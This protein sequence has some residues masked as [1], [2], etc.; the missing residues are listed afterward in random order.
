MDF[1]I[2]SLVMLLAVIASSWVARILPSLLPLPLIQIGLG[3]L[4]GLTATYRVTLAPD[5]F[6]LLFL[7]PLLFV[8]AWRSP[9]DALL[10][11]GLPIFQLAVGLVI[12]SVLG[13]GFAIHWTMSFVPLAVAFALAAVL[14]PTDAVAVSA[15][16]ERWAMPPRLLTILKGEALL[17]DASSLVC[18]HLA[19]VAALTGRFSIT[20][21]FTSFFALAIG[22][23]AIGIATT[24]LVAIVKYTIAYRFREDPTNQILIS[25]LMPFIAYLASEE[26]GVS[27]VLAA[28]AAGLTMSYVKSQGRAL[29]LTR[30][31]RRVVWDTVQATL[32]GMIFVL[33][34]EQLP[35]VVEGAAYTAAEAGHPSRWWLLACIVAVGVGL[36]LVQ[37]PVGMGIAVAGQRAAPGVQTNT[38]LY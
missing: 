29:A 26:F 21:A 3:A 34:G 12:F 27:G 13:V 5:V 38:L 33:L 28:V 4:I 15:I 7:P 37:L 14:S 1:I 20:H 10:Q 16:T 9:R 2:I 23:I 35:G 18:L 24:L 11:E 6:F 25:L 31:R 19:I 22:G 30:V 17:N 8:D 36:H 32:N